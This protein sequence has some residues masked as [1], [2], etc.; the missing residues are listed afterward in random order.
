[1]AN[2]I[3]LENGRYWLN[4]DR[5]TGMYYHDD[6]VD[7]LYL[8]ESGPNCQVV[9]SG[10]NRDRSQR[11]MHDIAAKIAKGEN[12]AQDWVDVWLQSDGASE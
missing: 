1:M 8:G 3:E 4:A 5:I 9:A 12:V 11:L 10:L 2:F 6:R 7:I